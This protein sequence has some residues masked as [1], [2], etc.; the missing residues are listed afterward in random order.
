MAN[1]KQ[2]TERRRAA[3]E[4]T[5]FGVNARIDIADD[6]PTRDTNTQDVETFIKQSIRRWKMS[7]DA[8]A[9]NRKEGL[10]DV[11]MVD[12][13]GQWDSQ[14][15]AKREAKKRP[16]L[17][18]NRFIPMISHVANEQRSAE[19][20]I[21]IDPT[22]GGSDPDTA[23]TLQ[24][25]IKHIEYDSSSDTV[26]DEAHDKM[27]EKGW[28]WVR[29]VSEYEDERSFDQKILFKGFENDF[30]V[31]ADPT[32]VEPTRK[33][34]R[35][36][37]VLE[38]IPLGEY[39]SLYSK[40][41]IAAASLTGVASVG[42]EAPEWVTNG[43]VRVVEYY[44]VD[45]KEEK[46][47]Q[48][49]SGKGKF[50]DELTTDDN[51][52][53]QE[54]GKTP[55]T[56]MSER[57][58][59]KWCK[60]NAIEILEGNEGLTAGRD[61]QCKYIPLIMFQGR[62][63]NIRGENRLSGM[64]RNNRDAQR[65][66]NYWVTAFTEMIALAPKSPFIA[67]AAQVAKYKNIWDSANEE[68]WPYLPYDAVSKEN[69]LV[70]PPTR[71]SVDPPV[72]AMI[73]AIRQAD[74][75]LKL[76]FNIFDAS[77]GQKGPQES[78]TAIN[79]RKVESESGNFNW[80]DN[81][82]RAVQHM[83]TIALDM[84]PSRYDAAR[85]ISIIRE[86]KQH[87]QV[88]I[89]QM[90]HD[91]KDGKDKT[92]DLTS[93]GYACVVSVGPKEGTKRQEAVSQM[94]ELVK[95]DPEIFKIIGDI[96]VDH[97]DWP[98]AAT[99]VKRLRQQLPPG[100]LE[101]S[102]GDTDE[103]IVK[104]ALQA[105]LTALSQ[106]HDQLVQALNAANDTIKSKKVETSSKEKIAVLQEQVKLAAILQKGDMEIFRAEVARIEA[107]LERFTLPEDDSDD[108]TGVPAQPGTSTGGASPVQT[109]A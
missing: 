50:E 65:M 37:H 60:H 19:L 77:L 49:T 98:D 3:V 27:L 96:I 23:E 56:R 89:N 62:K 109:S 59:V 16:C 44:Y 106:Q 42:D 57:K 54:D 33:D 30:C 105:K 48:T 101:S 55:M 84:I 34:M 47:F 13:E 40:S 85:T 92:I 93:G 10:I 15:K 80:L 102:D 8:E 86:D 20:S 107:E 7:A 82:R 41:R 52:V 64:V 14:V 51:L 70:P 46:L 78:G 91:K 5:R 31:Y 87:A 97:M 29:A 79:A 9:Y 58:T 35:W 76:G 103:A 45:S 69:S 18:I 95:V 24:G 53:F 12:G 22:G 71:N 73:M 1:R 38:D 6:D 4:E 75:D 74:N 39:L 28:S 83:G 88:M 26:I 66:Y 100:M 81:T 94:M 25:L 108:L 32:A 17:T 99:I 104:Q 36:G 68:A 21:K 43:T 61:L 63:K 90:F 67:E 72:Q 2:K 11:L